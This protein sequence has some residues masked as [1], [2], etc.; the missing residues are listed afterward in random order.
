MNSLTCVGRALWGLALA[1]AAMM[2]NGMPAGEAGVF[3]V[4]DY[5][6]VGDGKAVETAAINRAVEACSAAGGGQV[7]LTPGRYLSGTVRLRSHVTLLLEAGATLVG[8]PDLDAYEA[9]RPPPGTPEAGFKATWHRALILGDGVEDAAIVGP[10]RIDG[11][12]VFDPNGEEHRRGPHAILFG[13]CRGVTLRDFSVADAANYAVMLEGCEQVEARNLTVTGGWDGI[14]FRGW[15]DRPCRDVTI[16]DCRLFTGDDAIA[17]RYWD[18]VLITGCVLNSSCNGL[19]LIGPA[20]HLIVHHCLCYGPGR[21]LHRTSGR[22]N[23]L[24]ALALQPGAWDATEG[25]LDDVLIAD[26]TARH[27]TTPLH[28]SVHPGNRAGEVVVSRLSA[29]GVYEAAC[30]VESWADAPVG[31]I[32]LHDMSVE[33]AGGGT[34]EQAAAAVHRPGT[35]A[36]PLPAWGLYA[37]HVRQL[38]CENVRLTSAHEDFRPALLAEGVERLALDGLHLSRSP[39]GVEPMLL[40]DVGM[41]ERR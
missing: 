29:P 19:R 35:E 23:M 27:V 34:R 6:A 2:G 31:R 24:A 17:G 10:G 9:F 4:R 13:N 18:N 11:N 30:S 8:T 26:V 33:F 40:H 39:E 14:H 28:L 38:D 12:Q 22:H 16:A 20:T 36:R 1:G 21:F 7:R 37:R 15:R 41:V 25:D 5:G 32:S 3:N